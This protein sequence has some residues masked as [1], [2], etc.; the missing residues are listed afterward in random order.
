[1][2]QPSPDI[3]ILTAAQVIRRRVA[4]YLDLADQDLGSRLIMQSLC[5][6]I[7]EAMDGNCRHVALR[8]A[9][10]QVEVRYDAGMSLTDDPYEPG[11][12]QALALFQQRM[13]CHSRKKHLE[14]GTELCEIGLAVLTA[15]C[16]EL[17]AAIVAGG[18]TTTLRFVE[19]E[20]VSDPV[21]LEP[22]DCADST[23]IRFA[24]DETVLPGIQ[25][26]EAGLLRQ[27]DRVRETLP[28][29]DLRLEFPRD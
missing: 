10:D 5:H 18:L 3:E 23:C 20:L 11:R 14:V 1:M 4:M 21:K 26:D 12:P 22:S 17:D 9:A 6:A 2:A 7:D 24:L 29:L 27:S 13:A 28:Q 8:M 16:R 25:P 15:V 19:G